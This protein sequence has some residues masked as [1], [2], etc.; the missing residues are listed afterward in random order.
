[1]R[2]VLVIMVV[3]GCGRIHFDRPDG[4]RD[5]SVDAPE[6]M[7]D[8]ALACPAGTTELAAGST[9]CIELLERSPQ[10]WTTADAMCRAMGRKLCGD[11][12]WLL[13]CRS[14]S[15]VV[16]MYNDEDGMAQ[17]W[18]WVAEIQGSIASKRGLMSCDDASSVEA[19]S[20]AYDFRCC[21]NKL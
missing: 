21:T 14:A 20:I 12:E 2:S 15:G 5:G 18:E 8:A 17:S 3:A 10:G 16:D 4:S 7:I 1:M 19:D 6:V 9:V 11:A 13:A